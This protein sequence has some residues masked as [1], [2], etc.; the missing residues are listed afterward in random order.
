MFVAL[1]NV[2]L[3]QK[4][5]NLFARGEPAS[6]IPRQIRKLL[7][8]TVCSGFVDEMFFACFIVM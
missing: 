2:S 4:K 3:M 8:K 6:H 7:I 1:F 5:K